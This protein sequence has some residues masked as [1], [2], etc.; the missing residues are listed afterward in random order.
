MI[1]LANNP[2]ISRLL[3]IKPDKRLAFNRKGPIIR[4]LDL[5]RMRTV[6]FAFANPEVWAKTRH[7][8]FMSRSVRLTS[9]DMNNRACRSV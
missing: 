3:S 1:I 9:E 8:H 4:N 6:C 2:D 7:F 5:I